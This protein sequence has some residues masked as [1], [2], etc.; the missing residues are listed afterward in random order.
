[1]TKANN[2][3]QW[4]SNGLYFS[5]RG[6]RVFFRE[7]GA[8]E[9]IICLHGFPT[10]SYDFERLWEKLP[11]YRLI[12]P[13]FLGFGYS[14]KSK[15]IEYS[16]YDQASLVEDL[17]RKLGIRSCYLLAHDY[18]A[19]VAQELLARAGEERNY[20]FDIKAVIWMNGGIFPDQ[21]RPRFIQKALLTGAGPLLSRF[22]GRK[23]FGRQFSAIFGD[24]HKPSSVELDDFWEIVSYQKGHHL[25]YKLINYIPERVRNSDRWTGALIHFEG[26]M[27]FINGNQDPV[28]GK[29]MA[30]IYA[31]RVPDANVINL[32]DVGH[33]PQ[34]EAP[35]RCASEIIRFLEN[36]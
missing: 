5:F 33:Y 16:V 6:F 8:G 10:S 14:F 32:H 30:E 3:Q 7:Q 19:T 11:A 24:N 15:A 17:L 26:P 29:H 36:S 35:E 31:Q 23:R 9:A 20:A 34:W 2:P 22:L 25:A 1:M 4:K 18:G 12:A 13:D 21:H 28:S 27:L